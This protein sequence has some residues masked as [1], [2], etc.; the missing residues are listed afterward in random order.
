LQARTQWYA[1]HE[2]TDAG[3]PQREQCYAEAFGRN[4][5]ENADILRLMLSIVQV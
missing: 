3:T 1:C 4:F 5:G 2:Y